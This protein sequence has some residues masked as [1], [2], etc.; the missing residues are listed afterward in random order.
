MKSLSC[1]LLFTTPW[2]I[3]HQAPLSMGF[4][5][6]EYLSGVP[7][8]SSLLIWVSQFVEIPKQYQVICVSQDT[9]EFSLNNIC[10]HRHLHSKHLW[11][12][13]FQFQVTCG[14]HSFLFE[15][16]YIYIFNHYLILF[17]SNRSAC[18]THIY[19]LVAWVIWCPLRSPFQPPLSLDTQMLLRLDFLF[20]SKAV[21]ELG[22][23]CTENRNN[24]YSQHLLSSYCITATY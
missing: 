20:Q 12:A 1:V 3:V 23:L 21:L 22:I 14:I 8:P 7:S 13:P 10:E 19:Y 6:Q 11:R 4:S 24:K 2:T 17:S 9:F 5:R 15:V 18:K 16:L